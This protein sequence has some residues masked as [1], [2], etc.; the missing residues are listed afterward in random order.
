[1]SVNKIDIWTPMI[2]IVGVIFIVFFSLNI[3]SNRE[4]KSKLK[5]SLENE[6]KL[7]KEI[8]INKH[9]IDSLQ[10]EIEIRDSLIGRTI[11]IKYSLEEF[12]NKYEKNIN[13]IDTLSIDDN[14]KLFSREVGGE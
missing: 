3:I 14:I 8:E 1:M 11:I 13:S 2:S 10:S 12:K 7:M 5:S 9:K 4:I 6:I